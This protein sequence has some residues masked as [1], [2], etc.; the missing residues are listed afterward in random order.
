MTTNKQ[1]Q[2]EKILN[3]IAPVL[4]PPADFPPSSIVADTPREEL[5]A[6]IQENADKTGIELTDEHWALINFLFDFYTHCCEDTPASYLNRMAYWKYVDCDSSPDCTNPE[7]HA[8]EADCPYGKLSAN[9]A[10]RGYRVFRVLLKAF[11]HKGGKK[12]L[13][14]LFPLGPLFSI[15][16]LAQLPRLRDAVDPHFGTAF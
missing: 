4:L 11:Q 2:R 7:D 14:R 15:H 1:E 6:R 5:N 10:I 9:E 8:D 16:L 3:E 12:H 13:Y